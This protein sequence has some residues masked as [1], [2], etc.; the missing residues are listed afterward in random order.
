MYSYLENMLVGGEAKLK[1]WYSTASKKFIVDIVQDGELICRTSGKY[2]DESL[3]KYIDM[4]IRE[5]GV[6][7]GS[8]V[9]V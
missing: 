3:L 8:G 6:T 1:I 7:E 5:E 4:E 9:Y 2:L